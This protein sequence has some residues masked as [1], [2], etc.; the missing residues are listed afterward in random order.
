[1]ISVPPASIASR[2]FCQPQDVEYV[3]L[4]IYKHIQ[5]GDI[6]AAH[7]RLY[8]CDEARRPSIFQISSSFIV[9]CDY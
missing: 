3:F 9:A 6:L 5:K 8:N 2:A 4:N 7:G 1:M